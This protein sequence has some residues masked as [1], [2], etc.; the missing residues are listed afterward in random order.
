MISSTGHF[1]MFRDQNG[2]AEADRHDLPERPA[3]RHV[4]DDV[5]GPDEGRDVGRR[6]PQRQDDAD[7]RGEARARVAVLQV[8]RHRLDELL[9]VARSGLGQ[10]VDQRLGP[11]AEQAQQRYHHQQPG[12]DRQDRVVG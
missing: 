7:D 6:R 3:L 11:R 4:I 2:D 1:A 10:V 5:G 12:E 8:G 9:D